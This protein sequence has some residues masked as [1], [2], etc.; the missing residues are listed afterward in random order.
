MKILRI[1]DIDKNLS[2]NHG[3]C[4]KNLEF[5]I[6]TFADVYLVNYL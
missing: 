3:Y 6:E 4:K 5:F 1:I 2:K